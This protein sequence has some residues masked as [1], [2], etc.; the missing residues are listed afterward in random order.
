M[1]T[2]TESSIIRK[3]NFSHYRQ[4]TFTLLMNFYCVF[5]RKSVIRRKKYFE[6]QRNARSL[7]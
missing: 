1:Q 3:N 2:K 6:K 4:K 7:Y 5:F